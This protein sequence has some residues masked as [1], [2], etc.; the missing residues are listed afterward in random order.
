MKKHRSLCPVARSLD[1][2]GD[3]WTLLI[4]RDVAMFG[5]TTF[6]EIAQMDEGIATNTLAERLDR[7]VNEA[8]LTKTQSA[9]NKLVYHYRITQKGIDLIPVLQNISQWAEKHLYVASE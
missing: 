6:K 2:F 8:M 1:I 9:V 3:K 5:K 4:L 7:L